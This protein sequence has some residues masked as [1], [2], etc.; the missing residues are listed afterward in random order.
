M[1]FEENIVFFIFTTLFSGLIGNYIAHRLKKHFELSAAERTIEERKLEI[2]TNLYFSTQDCFGNVINFDDMNSKLSAFCKKLKENNT[3]FLHLSTKCIRLLNEFHEQSKNKDKNIFE[4]EYIRDALIVAIEYDLNTTKENLGYSNSI[5]DTR[6]L[7][8][9]LCVF[10]SCV[11]VTFFFT[12]QRVINPDSF[13]KEDSN[14]VSIII[15]SSVAV[16]VVARWYITPRIPLL[17]RRKIKGHK[18]I[19]NKKHHSII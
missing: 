19:K 10:C 5:K 15:L 9:S 6:K 11:I 14:I 17:W 7:L 18:R 1:T 2:Y 8:F 4:F 3:D 16:A 12:F 13:T